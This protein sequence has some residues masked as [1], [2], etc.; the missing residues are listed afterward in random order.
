MP[1][2]KVGIAYAISD[3]CVGVR[4][5]TLDQTRGA[6]VEESGRCSRGLG[7]KMDLGLQIRIRAVKEERAVKR[8]A[9]NVRRAAH[10]GRALCVT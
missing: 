6:T 3:A 2:L 1:A 10:K 9:N 8:D 5:H 4:T 7:A